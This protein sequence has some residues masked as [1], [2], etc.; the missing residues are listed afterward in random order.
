[1]TLPVTPNRYP[2]TVR[3][4]VSSHAR[5]SPSQPTT[6]SPYNEKCSGLW[7][8]SQCE[9]L[10][11]TGLATLL[12]RLLLNERGL[13]TMPTIQRH[14]RCPQLG[15]AILVYHNK[16]L[17]P[18]APLWQVQSVKSQLGYRRPHLPRCRQHH[19]PPVH[20]GPSEPG[21]PARR[22]SAPPLRR[23]ARLRPRLRRLSLPT[24]RSQKSGIWERQ[25]SRTE[26]TIG[27]IQR[28]G[29]PETFA[30]WRQ[31]YRREES[32]QISAH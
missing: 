15:D 29:L 22:M 27:M 19:Q 8:S 3:K 1:M 21:R 31:A 2:P 4:Q 20:L 11:L 10:I 24:R 12:C 30:A 23:R 18:K 7:R 25:G 14:A 5:L 28:E 6:C 26:T 17:K 16:V 9:E 32:L 13:R